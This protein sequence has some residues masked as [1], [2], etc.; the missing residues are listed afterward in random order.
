MYYTVAL[1]R[2]YAKQGR[3]ACNAMAEKARALFE[4]DAEISKYYNQTL[5]GGKWNHLMDQTHIGYTYWQQPPVDKI[6][7]L[8]QYDAP[9]SAQMGIAVEGNSTART[10][11]ADPLVLPAFHALRPNEKHF[12]DVFNT[13]KTPFTFQIQSNAKYL[14]ITATTGSIQDEQRIDVSID[15]NKAPQGYT[16][17]PVN[18][19]ASTGQ[20]IVV[21]LDIQNARLPELT[22]FKGFIETDGSVSTHAEHYT[23]AV[24]SGAVKW[25]ILPDIGRVAGAITSSPTTHS[26]LSPAGESPHLEYAFYS[27]KIGEVS[28]QAQFS[29]TL[30][31]NESSGLRYG[32]SIDDG[33][34]QTINLHQNKSNQAWEASVANNIRSLNS[35]HLLTREGTHTLKYWAIDPGV[36]LQK[37]V[38]DLGGV[39]TS[40]LGPPESPR[41]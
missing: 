33:P 10:S 20:T 6:P 31:F 22:D 40:Y 3:S 21:Y 27:A 38:I 37:L 11:A 34:I 25:Q 41:K 12:I 28:V 16:R 36:V 32:I 29:P 7:D 17:I 2:L 23:H 18:I 1:N 4:R 5:A 15:W 8:I 9:L 13:G 14:N 30:E 24:E 19:K 26:A 35:T 39:K